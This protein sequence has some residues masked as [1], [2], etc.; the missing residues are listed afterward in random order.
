MPSFEAIILFTTAA[1]A[2][3]LCP[4]PS[5]AY[6]MSRSIGQGRSAGC[7][8]ALGL[9]TGLLLHTIAASMGLSVVF[10]CSPL[11]YIIV[12]YLGAAYLLYLGMQM[13]LSGKNERDPQAPPP[14]SDKFRVYGQGV[15][16]EILNPKTALFYLSFLPQFVD[17]FQGHPGLQ[18]FIL[19]C[20]LLLT[21]LSMDLFIAVTGGAMSEWFTRNPVFKKGQQ[22]LAG[23]V[24]IGLGIRLAISEGR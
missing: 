1:V 24:L 5:M 14:K 13:F 3:T 21:A 9:A 22:W 18:M 10:V 4:G 7:F 16:T 11:I 2:I 12:K 17:P 6:V 23:T 20:I 8:S 19:G 15:I